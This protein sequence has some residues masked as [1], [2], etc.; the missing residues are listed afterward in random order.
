MKPNH[1]ENKPARESASNRIRFE[2]T[3]SDAE[4][5]A[6][7]GTF[8]DWH[9]TATPMIAM[10]RGRWAK[11]LVLPPGDY[12]YCL[13]VDGRW[14]PDPREAQSRPNP[15]GG[16]NSIRKVSNGRWVRGQPTPP[17]ATA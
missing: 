5:V 13:V 15:F 17:G 7:A 8:N 9:P 16:R 2:Y 12:E 6:I 3:S 14:I 1:A 11:D 10:G 4:S